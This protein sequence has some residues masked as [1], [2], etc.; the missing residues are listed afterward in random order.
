MLL[1]II[2]GG[3]MATSVEMRIFLACV[4]SSSRSADAGVVDIMTRPNSAVAVPS[5]V[6]FVILGSPLLL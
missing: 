6:L 3:G 2:P 5:S 1:S 4:M